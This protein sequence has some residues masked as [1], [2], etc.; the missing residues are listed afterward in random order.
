VKA[1]SDGRAAPGEPKAVDVS[2]ASFLPRLP[3]L[4]HVGLDG[5]WDEPLKSGQKGQ[6]GLEVV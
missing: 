1:A 4:P 2:L 5:E 3:I 6:F